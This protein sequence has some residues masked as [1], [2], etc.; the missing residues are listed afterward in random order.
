MENLKDLKT[1]TALVQEILEENELARN[2]DSML[3][4]CVLKHY[5]AEYNIDIDRMSLPCF[6]LHF[7][8]YPLPTIES[9]GRTRRKVL[10]LH[11]ELAG[12]KTVQQGRAEKEKVYKAY[13][14]QRGAA[15]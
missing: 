10:E 2:S 1:L 4:Y 9:V 15:K 6:L 12:N 5:G 8:E 7:R 3:Y 14:R 11:P 13:A